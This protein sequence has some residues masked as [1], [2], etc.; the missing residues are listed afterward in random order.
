M[1]LKPA[2]LNFWSPESKVLPSPLFAL[3]RERRI[4]AISVFP[5]TP[6]APQ[7]GP[8]PCP[9]FLSGAGPAL[10]PG[11]ARAPGSSPGNNH[12]VDLRYEAGPDASG[13]SPGTGWVTSLGTDVFSY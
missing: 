13:C 7:P 5:S 12:H 6:G 3:K 4:F 2:L 8:G 1:S 10:D 11:A 9:T